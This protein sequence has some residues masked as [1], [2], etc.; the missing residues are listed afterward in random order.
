MGFDMGME[1]ENVDDEEPEL[2]LPYQFEGPPYPHLPYFLIL[3]PWQI[4]RG[5]KRTQRDLR[6]MTEWAYDF[7]VGML[8]IG[9]VGVRTMPPRRLRGATSTKRSKRAA[10]E[11]LIADRVAEAIA[12]IL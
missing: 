3:N 7:Y 10:M 5:L 8:R 12:V 4:L 9:V 1:W 6:K 11:K 2:I